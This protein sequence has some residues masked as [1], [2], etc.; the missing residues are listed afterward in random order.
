MESSH[1]HG[2]Y[3]ILLVLAMD[4]LVSRLRLLEFVLTNELSRLLHARV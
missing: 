2:D 1:H 4:G 3:Q